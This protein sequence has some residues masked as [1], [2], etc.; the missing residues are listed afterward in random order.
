MKS[1]DS[2]RVYAVVLAAGKGTRMKSNTP[3]VL[4]EVVGKPLVGHVVQ[5]LQGLSIEKIVCVVGHGA[6]LVSKYIRTF[7]CE[8]VVQEEQ[9]GTGHAVACA[10]QSLKGFTGNVFIICGDTPLF[11]SETIARFLRYHNES[12][13]IV[14]VLSAFFSNP[15]GYGRIV[16]D[17]QG[18]FNGIVEEKDADENIRSISEVNTGTYV[19]RA[20]FLFD[21]LKGLD[22]NNMQQEYYLTDI[23][24]AAVRQGH[25]VD[26]YPLCSEEEALGVNSRAQL[27]RAEA[28]MLERKRQE[29]MDQGVTIQN[30]QTVY[31]E[32]DVAV[33]ADSVIEPCVVLKGRTS[34]GSNVRVGAFSYLENVSVPDGENLGPG[35]RMAG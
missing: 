21:A 22:N 7:G 3:K 15:A 11:Q 4:H 1:S 26:A 34:V 32:P 10:E 9:L 25:R 14:S 12:G 2:T 13:S 8:T 24:A 31:V 27:S 33:G 17:E 5:L 28:V 19:V 20:E 35:T 29:L 16:R 23:V 18:C 30:A 6:G